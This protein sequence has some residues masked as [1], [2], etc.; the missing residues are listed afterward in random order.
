MSLSYQCILIGY[1][2]HGC[3]IAEA[4]QMSGFE[5]LGYADIRKVEKNP[6]S[7]NYLGSE[8]DD[9]FA[10]WG[11]GYSFI[12]GIGDN[13][14]RYAICNFIEERNEIVQ[15][16]IH[17]SAS[18]S[19]MAQIGTGVFISRNVSINPLSIIGDFSIVN[20]SSIIE[21]ECLIGKA[22]HIAPGAVLAGN[23]TVGDRSF[24]GANSVIKQ[25]VIVGNDVIIGAGSVIIKDI[26]DNSCVVGNPS[27]FLNRNYVK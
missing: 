7:L 10:Q 8:S 21:H 6:F 4:A 24:V 9:F 20:T 2:G 25:G 14:I 15:K 3:V 18:V 23:V 26:P 1:S 16:I 5:L 17:P 11:K 19:G 22:A 13:K 12:C 27:K